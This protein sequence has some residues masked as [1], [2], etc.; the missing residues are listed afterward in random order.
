VHARLQ[1]ISKLILNT[2]SMIVR[3]K[4]YITKNNE[5]FILL[6]AAHMLTNKFEIQVKY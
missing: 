4:D 3:I 5:P 1:K 6:N 2:K